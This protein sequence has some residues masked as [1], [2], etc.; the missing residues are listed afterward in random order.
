MIRLIV[1]LK[2]LLKLQ[3]IIT[4]LS[5]FLIILG[6]I[7]QILFSSFTFAIIMILAG[8]LTLVGF[9]SYYRRVNQ[10][11]NTKEYGKR[12][13]L[14]F[15][16]VGVATAFL[17]PTLSLITVENERV[18]FVN[19]FKNWNKSNIFLSIKYPNPLVIPIHYTIK[20]LSKPIDVNI[21]HPKNITVN[22]IQLISPEQPI[23]SYDGNF[24]LVNKTNNTSSYNAIIT[25]R[26]YDEISNKTY[27]YNIR[28]NYLNQTD[29]TINGEDIKFEWTIIP[30]DLIWLQYFWIVLS[31]VVSSRFISFVVNT[32]TTEVLNIDR[33]EGVWIIFTFIIA[34]LAFVSF[35]ENVDLK[36]SVFFNV[37]AAFVFGF[38][39]QKVLEV[40]REFPRFQ[41]IKSVLPGKVKDLEPHIEGNNIK[42]IWTNNTEPDLVYYNIYRSDQ[43]NFKTDD[44]TIYDRSK[45]ASYVDSETTPGTRY[46]YKVAAVNAQNEVGDE[47]EEITIQ[48]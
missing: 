34:V 40:A 20:D 23:V 9:W 25:A 32:N 42:L 16:I 29:D 28:L 2:Y 21:T 3:F 22:S 39:S 8:T 36:E 15:I 46:Y 17:I 43:Q 31:G 14:G 48:R 30:K 12:V 38:G 10:D 33:T 26:H 27:N 24:K 1:L 44:A 13:T 37:I 4:S 41:T 5:I 47:S 19:N 6:F 7:I 35:K 11:V 45:K 18:T